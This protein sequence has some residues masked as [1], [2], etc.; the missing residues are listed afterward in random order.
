MTSPNQ[1]PRFACDAMLGGLARWLRAAGFDASWHPD[2]ADWDLIRLARSEGR[3]LLSCDTGIFRI[4]IVR[5]G[6]MPAL[7]IPQDLFTKEKQLAFVLGRMLLEPQRPR[8]MACG[9]EL[10][11][12]PKEQVR[13]RAPARTFAEVERFYE[14]NRCGQLFWEGTHW[15]KIAA[16]L[17]K[18][19][20][21]DGTE[22]S[23]DP[24]L[25]HLTPQI[26]PPPGPE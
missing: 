14:C 10:A 4:G 2:I 26:P 22:D 20:P 1:P 5:D 13:H 17:R 15:Q 12:V 19:R 7:L 11:A 8:C 24:A 18:I 6:E 21:G 9:G 16:V 3:V 25:R 23:A